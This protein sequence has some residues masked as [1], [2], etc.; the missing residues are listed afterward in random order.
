MV[1]HIDGEDSH[2]LT[3]NNEEGMR[4][5]SVAYGIAELKRQLIKEGL[6]PDFVHAKDLLRAYFLGMLEDS[7]KARV[8]YVLSIESQVLAN[9]AG[10]LVTKKVPLFIIADKNSEDFF[11]HHVVSYLD[12]VSR[13]VV[14]EPEHFEDYFSVTGE[15][16]EPS[17]EI[18]SFVTYLDILKTS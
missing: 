4:F 3:R 1:L 12:H 5:D 2:V 7:F 14:I 9:L 8:E 6:A 15:Y 11:T 18:C 10:D 16:V 17:V 13:A